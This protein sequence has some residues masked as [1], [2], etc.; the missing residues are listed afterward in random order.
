MG[1]KAHEDDSAKELKKAVKAMG[2][3]SKREETKANKITKHLSENEK[4]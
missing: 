3:P 4:I 1:R 2:K